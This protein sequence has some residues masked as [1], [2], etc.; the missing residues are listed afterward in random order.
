MTAAGARPFR[1]NRLPTHAF[2]PASRL[3]T[4]AQ[5]RNGAKIEVPTSQ[6]AMGILPEFL[7]L[8]FRV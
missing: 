1:H 8:V 2:P 3:T 7:A 4:A 5:Q 6:P